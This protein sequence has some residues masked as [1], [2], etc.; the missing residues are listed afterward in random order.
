MANDKLQWVEWTDEQI[1]DLRLCDLGLKIPASPVAPY[2]RQL[3][4]EMKQRGL[5]FRPHFWLSDDWFW[6]HVKLVR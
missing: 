4:R 2:I 1:L 6:V 3:Y 5:K